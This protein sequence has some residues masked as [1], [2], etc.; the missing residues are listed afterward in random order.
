[1][2]RLFV[3]GIPALLVAVAL[4]AARASAGPRSALTAV[5][6]TVK[7]LVNRDGWYRVSLTALEAAGF[8][9]PSNP[10]LI[11]LTMD[12]Q[13]IP[14]E[15]RNGLLEFYGLSLDTLYTDT[16]TYW[17]SAGATEGTPV[18]FARARAVPGAVSGSFDAVLDTVDRKQYY[19]AVLSRAAAT[20][21]AVFGNNIFGDAVFSGGPLTRQIALGNVDAAQSAVLHLDLYGQSGN[22]R[23]IQVSV[24]GSGT[25]GS[26]TWSGMGAGSGD[27]SIP[28]NTLTANANNTVTLTEVGPGSDF[29]TTD[30]Y[31]LTYKHSY[32]ADSNALSFPVTGGQV[33]TVGGFTSNGIRLLDLSNP[34]S[35]RELFGTIATSGTTFKISAT[36]PQGATR[37]YAFADPAVLAPNQVVAD[38][39][40]TLKTPQQADLIVIAYK[41]A[42]R[43]LLTDVQP[44]VQA[45]QND[46]LAVKVVD[47]QDVYD[48]FGTPLGAK[49]PAAI[50]S[51]L[52]YAKSNWTGSANATPKYVLL[53]GDATYDP[54]G[55][56]SSASNDLIPTTFWDATFSEAPSDDAL[57]DFNGDGKPELAVGR[58][59]VRTDTEANALVSKIVNYSATAPRARTATLVA[60]NFDRGDYRFDLFSTDLKTTSL[61]P[62]GVTSTTINR[63]SCPGTPPPSTCSSDATT[64]TS[65]VNAIN[66]GPVLV[67]W[68]GHGSF[69]A[70][71]GNLLVK[72]DAPGLTNSNALSLF[73][74]MTC[75]TGYFVDPNGNQLGES[76]LAASGGA[77]AVWASTGDTVPFDQV[78]AAKVA[79]NELF[80]APV[81]PATQRR[82]LGDA[83]LD[84][85]NSISDIDVLHTWA[86]LGDPTMRLNIQ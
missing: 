75:Q 74:M 80:A 30:A 54:R 81:P 28:A 13:E 33:V 22:S 50:T 34:P 57:A 70:W 68:F 60:D 19:A 76:L 64:H 32:L 61:D 38:V 49:G 10:N 4:V 73:M 17:L 11:H 45:R 83:M 69:G 43:N 65:V 40:S 39:P 66:T 8:V 36:V 42:T 44:L 86:L 41:D 35:P 72:A 48:E 71:N 31:R 56:F 85:K 25:L 55:Y 77:V 15:L 52:Q 82:R 3:F 46:G 78:N 27:I 63:P 20:R 5:S 14:Y 62:N 23:T 9:T 51:F 79:T 21:G 47:V 59:P 1:M 67:N 29:V 26:I 2:R 24:N 16:R 6:P 7:I 37:L 58:L 84:A 12:G 53:A 18:S